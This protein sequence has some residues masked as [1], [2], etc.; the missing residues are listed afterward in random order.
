MVDA[1]DI[2]M[3]FG[4]HKGKKLH[5]IPDAYLEWL[6]TPHRSSLVA[7]AA[8]AVLNQRHY[9]ARRMQGMPSVGGRT[10]FFLTIDNLRAIGSYD[11]IEDGYELVDDGYVYH[12][13]FDLP[14]DALSFLKASISNESGCFGMDQEDDEFIVWEVNPQGFRRGVW[15]AWGWHHS[16]RFY[17]IGQG[18]LPGCDRTLYDMSGDDD[19]DG[20]PPSRHLTQLDDEEN[21]TISWGDRE[22]D[23]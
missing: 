5:D 2:V 11:V 19:D 1:L 6:A 13:P 7:Q 10:E 8:E 12:Q 20:E 16:Q 17:G 4:M 23:N 15:Q 3:P 9:A 14:D 22:Y 21:D 18:K